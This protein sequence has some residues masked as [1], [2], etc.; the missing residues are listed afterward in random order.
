MRD[1]IKKNRFYLQIWNEL[2]VRG[3]TFGG[4]SCAEFYFGFFKQKHTKIF[5]ASI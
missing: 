4:S 2:L 1:I 5:T 3:F